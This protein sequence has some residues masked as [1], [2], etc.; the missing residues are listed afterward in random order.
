V[1]NSFADHVEDDLLEAYSLERLRGADLDYVE[2]H[3]FICQDC[4]CR[5]ETADAFTRTFRAAA[6]Q[7]SA[8][9]QA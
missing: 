5:L 9:R 4:R 1:R 6:R 3:L 7:L 8:E 2:E